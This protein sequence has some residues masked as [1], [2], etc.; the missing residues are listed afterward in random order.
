MIICF[1]LINQI[2]KTETRKNE[3]LKLIKYDRTQFKNVL[4]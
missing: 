3:Y 1:Y 4:D 2:D